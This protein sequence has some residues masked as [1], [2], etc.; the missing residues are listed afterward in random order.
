MRTGQVFIA[1]LITFLVYRFLL[2][3]EMT[4]IYGNPPA[5]RCEFPCF[6]AGI[7]FIAGIMISQTFTGILDV[8]TE[9]NLI[10]LVCDQ[11]MF[12]GRQRFCFGEMLTFMAEHGEEAIHDYGELN[13]KIDIGK[14]MQV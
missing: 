1:S 13:V 6:I 7:V 2:T 8:V 5:Y 4:Q 11:E 3:N 9:T 14:K 12:T 10:C